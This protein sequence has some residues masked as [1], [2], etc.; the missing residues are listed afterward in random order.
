MGKLHFP[1]FNYCVPSI[2][3]FIYKIE[4]YPHLCIENMQ[5]ASIV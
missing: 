3:Y 4:Q 5:I 1:P 2:P